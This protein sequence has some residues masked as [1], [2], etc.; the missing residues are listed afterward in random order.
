MVFTLWFFEQYGDDTLIVH[1]A[2]RLFLDL[3]YVTQISVQNKISKYMFV[4]WSLCLYHDLVA[5]SLASD[6]FEVRVTDTLW[7]YSEETYLGVI[8]HVYLRS[9]HMGVTGA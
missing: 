1:L 9:D 7:H 5:S 2:L 6:N 4:N 3:N 8:S